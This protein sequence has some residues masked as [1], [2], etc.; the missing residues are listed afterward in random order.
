MNEEKRPLPSPDDV[1]LRANPVLG[2]PVDVWDQ[3]NKY[4]T[5]EVQDTT[6]T[7]NVFP[8][9]GY[10]GSENACVDAANKMIKKK[11]EL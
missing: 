7:D 10:E 2:E 1:E 4:G 3:I 5:Y 8:C 6:D 11:P 9:I